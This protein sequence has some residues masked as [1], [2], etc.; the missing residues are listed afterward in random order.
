MASCGP[1]AW[2][3]PWHA[4]TCP[5]PRRT[6]TPIPTADGASCGSQAR[7]RAPGTDQSE[8]VHI[9][10]AHLPHAPNG[11]HIPFR[12]QYTLECCTACHRL[13]HRASSCGTGNADD[14]CAKSKRGVCAGRSIAPDDRYCHQLSAV[15]CSQHVVRVDTRLYACQNSATSIFSWLWSLWSALRGDSSSKTCKRGPA[16]EPL[17]AP[18][19]AMRKSLGG[20][21]QNASVSPDE[22]DCQWATNVACDAAMGRSARTDTCSVACCGVYSKAPVAVKA[23]LL[24]RPFVYARSIEGHAA[25]TIFAMRHDASSNTSTLYYALDNTSLGVRGLWTCLLYTSPSPR[26]GLLSR[27]P[28]SA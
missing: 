21:W 15:E 3:E 22:C 16:C 27:M 28:S 2:A 20:R 11:A 25:V 4:R 18:L 7:R 8:L 9:W 24:C 23:P 10:L 5:H 14:V 1:R 19:R 6:E 17:A 13:W 12:P 26:D